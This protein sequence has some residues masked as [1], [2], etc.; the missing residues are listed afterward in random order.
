MVLPARHHLSKTD[1]PRVQP[2]IW[3]DWITFER[4]M[5]ELGEPFFM[6]PESSQ[7]LW[8]TRFPERTVLVFGSETAGL[9]SSIRETYS[10]RL[11]SL[12]MRDSALRSLNLSTC[13][14]IA[15]YEVLRQWATVAKR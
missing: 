3:P 8:E 9:P 5:G 4:R 6:S 2:R 1:W 13:V 15:L 14:G 11:V 12:P 10:D 7:H